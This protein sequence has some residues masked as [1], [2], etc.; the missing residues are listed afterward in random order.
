MVLNDNESKNILEYGIDIEDAKL[1]IEALKNGGENTLL[2]ESASYELGIV[3]LDEKETLLNATK[4]LSNKTISWFVPASG[5][6]SRMFKELN[7]ALT[8]SK[9]NETSLEFKERIK[10]FPFY[11]ELKLLMDRDSNK[12]DPIDLL[13][14]KNSLN[15]ALKPKAFIAFHKYSALD[16]RTAMEEHFVEAG[17]LGADKENNIKIHFTLS[18]DHL[19]DAK[20]FISKYKIKYLDKYSTDFIIDTSFQE[21]STDTIALNNTNT[22]FKEQEDKE[23]LLFRPGGHG[24]LIKNLQNINTD[25][26]IVKNIDNTLPDRSKPLHDKY[27]KMV[28]GYTYKVK[29]LIDSKIKEIEDSNFDVSDFNK[30]LISIGFPKKYLPGI[31]C[32]QEAIKF[33]DRPLRVCGMV[34]TTG[35]TGGG[36]FWVKDN[37]NNSTLQIVETAEINLDDSTQTDILHSANFFNPVDIVCSIKDRNGKKYNLN[38]YINKNRALIVDKNYHGRSLKAY[39][40]PGLWNGAMHNWLNIFVDVPAETFAPVKSVMDLIGTAHTV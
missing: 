21:K 32:K 25:F 5:A 36:P 14:S 20:D 1:Q 37:N 29:D 24:S 19:E 40:R 7:E 28:L 31:S 22:L 38:N 23:K 13:L 8:L 10:E 35:D 30:F 11:D 26:I 39:E 6:A 15:F 33:L 3:K 2:L 16:I 17:N 34:R 18:E 9:D 27:K 12:Q 4:C